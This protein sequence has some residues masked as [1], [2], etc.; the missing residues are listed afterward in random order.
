M[1]ID[2]QSKPRIYLVG[3]F[4]EGSL[5]VVRTRKTRL[6]FRT[7]LYEVVWPLLVDRLCMTCL[8]KKI[9]HILYVINPG[10]E[11]LRIQVENI[12]YERFFFSP[13]QIILSVAGFGLRSITLYSITEGGLRDV[14]RLYSAS[15]RHFLICMN[16]LN[17]KEDSGFLRLG[18]HYVVVL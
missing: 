14:V 10:R 4:T 11:S 7:T 3:I 15:D 6:Q 8:V 17:G 2:Y 12:S 9:G 16:S 18:V 1:H 13:S 5:K